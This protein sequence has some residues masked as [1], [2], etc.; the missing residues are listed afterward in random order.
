MEKNI[1]DDKFN[2]KLKTALLFLAVAFSLYFVVLLAKINR[3]NPIL[4]VIAPYIPGLPSGQNANDIKNFSSEQDFKDYLEASSK[5][6][7]GY[8]GGINTFSM[9]NRALSPSAMMEKS[10]VDGIGGGGTP[11]RISE[12]NVQVIG[13]DEPD[14]VK[15]DGKEIYFSGNQRY[16]YGPMMRG[17]VNSGISWEEQKMIVPDAIRPYPIPQEKTD[18][19]KAFPP[20]DLALDGKIDKQGDL[21]LNN[22]VLV[23]FSNTN[24]SGSGQE[25]NGYDISN[26][27]SP[28]K[29][30]TVKLDNNTSVVTSRLNNGKIYLITRNNINTPR[31]CPL[32]PLT[33][34]GVELNIRCA[35]IYHPVQPV[36]IDSTFIAMVLNPNTG[37]IE[38]TV[39]FVGSSGSSV[40]YVS[41]NAIYA[42]YTYNESIAKFFSGFVKE[43]GD[44]FPSWLSE[45]VIK[46]EEYDIS[47]NSKLQEILTLVEK[48]NNTLSDDE[49]LKAGNEMTNRMSDYYK[50]HNRDLEKTG[51]VKIDLN[52][53][54]ITATGAVPG[55][56]LNNFAMDEYKENLRIASTIGSRWGIFNG[57]GTGESV[58]DVTIL[59][60]NLDM[61]GSVRDLGKTEQIYSV[62]F[63]E[64]KGYVVTFRQTDPFYVLDLSNPKNPKLAGELKIPGYSSYLHPLDATHI[65]GVGMEGNKV[66]I[67]LFDVSDKNNPVEL[68]KYMLDEYWTE[69]SNNYHAFLLDT[70]HDIFFLPG[71]KGGYV[72]SYVKRLSSINDLITIPCSPEEVCTKRTIEKNSIYKL[73]LKKAVSQNSVKRA[74]YINDYLY[75]IGD[76]KITILNELDWQ[77]VN[78]LSLQ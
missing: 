4:P 7:S 47:E 39:S 31:P 24:Y 53:F 63:I 35:D 29:R 5:L 44:L 64:D 56:L 72:F 77:K 33:V 14:I 22:D 49:K 50:A 46:L 9:M 55:H 6:S 43:N 3:I 12:T 27:K 16:Y 1:K 70:K 18:I 32:M 54:Q 20:A 60:K 66:K 36:P 71:S 62:R 23:V 45:K 25:I 10:A 75:I 78:E 19:I 48:Y 61:I 21:L 30:W 15:T 38:D 42:T 34:N 59:D 52:K 17:D 40:V 41:K 74:I 26:P 69:V 73:E 65:L 57:I 68:D 13:I 28:V 67:S 37:K 11:D 58:N 8:G 76:D 2:L 51:I